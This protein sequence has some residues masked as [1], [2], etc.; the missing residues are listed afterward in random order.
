M[1]PYSHIHTLSRSLSRTH[2]GTLDDLL[3]RTPKLISQA[4]LHHTQAL[5][6][7]RQRV[8]EQRLWGGAAAGAGDDDDDDDGY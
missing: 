1:W 2:I 3:K 4:L 8:Q 7:D 6:A 5:R